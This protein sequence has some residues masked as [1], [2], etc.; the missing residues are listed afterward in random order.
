MK[1][2][3]RKLSRK[4]I[5][6]RGF[7]PIRTVALFSLFRNPAFAHDL[8]F[9][10]DLTPVSDWHNPFFVASNVDRYSAFERA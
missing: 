8:K 7:G 10:I 6:I 2:L 4:I 5:A 9:P 1:Q 3:H